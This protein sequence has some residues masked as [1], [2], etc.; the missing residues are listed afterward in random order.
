MVPPL[1]SA[2]VSLPLTTARS[3]AGGVYTP[4]IRIRCTSRRWI[5]RWPIQGP[6]G[7]LV[8]V[9]KRVTIDD[10]NEIDER[11]FG[12]GLVISRRTSALHDRISAHLTSMCSQLV[13][14]DEIGGV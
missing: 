6:C 7:P 5:A 8:A 2:C 3:G 11:C 14:H 4:S 9:R 13:K 12:V 1:P 10:E